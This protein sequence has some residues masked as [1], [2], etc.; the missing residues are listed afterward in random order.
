ML[1]DDDQLPSFLKI[2]K[3]LIFKFSFSNLKKKKKLSNAPLEINQMWF[4]P[5]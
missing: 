4:S 3:C 2:T 1:S 5:S